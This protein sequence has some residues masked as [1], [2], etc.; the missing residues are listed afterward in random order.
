[1]PN[2]KAR[3]KRAKTRYTRT[4]PKVTVNKQLQDIEIGQKVE[5]AIDYSVHSAMP[6]RRYRGK[7][8]IITAKRGRKF[9]I[10]VNQGNLPKL[11]IAGPEHL[12]ISGA[13]REKNESKAEAA[14]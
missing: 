2:K 7:S 12:A 11:I 10:D 6:A 4:L 13:K 9:V 14:A 8:G 1:M 3:G 5:I